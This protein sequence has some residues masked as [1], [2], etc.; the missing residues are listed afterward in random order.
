MDKR[1]LL[2]IV[3]VISL[4]SIISLTSAQ[5][6]SITPSTI[7]LNNIYPGQT[8][9]QNI[10]I[11]S[12]SDYLV[13][14]NA[15]NNVSISPYLLN[16][17]QGDNNIT[18]NITIPTNLSSGNLEFDINAYINESITPPLTNEGSGSGGSGS[19]QSSCM[20]QWSCSNWSICEN[21]IQI[22]V[23]SYPQN[24]CLP[25]SQKPTT[26]QNCISSITNNTTNETSKP[27]LTQQLINNFKT[28]PTINYIGAGITL[29][30]VVIIL[31]I[32]KK[33]FKKRN[34]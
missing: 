1:I 30:I 26:S 34:K 32:L 28:L 19:G 3:L 18:L 11:S 10:T 22:R 2:E 33:K 9:Q 20:T 27:S 7:N 13:L 12:D 15:T 8:Y 24:Y 23:C 6:I 5:S 17:T 14:L 16:I 25:T 31:I 21:N 29:G 4:I